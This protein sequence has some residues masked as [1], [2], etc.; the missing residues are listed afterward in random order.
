MKIY[1]IHYI[2]HNIIIRVKCPKW[3]NCINGMKWNENVFQPYTLLLMSLFNRFSSFISC[4]LL[5]HIHLIS[6]LLG[7]FHLCVLTFWSSIFFYSIFQFI[8]HTHTP[9]KLNDF[10]CEKH[11]VAIS[12]IFRMHWMWW[13]WLS[14]LQLFYKINKFRMRSHQ[15]LHPNTKCFVLAELLSFCFS[16][17]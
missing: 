6:L 5:R 1:L 14:Y 13:Y 17:N 2:V 12:R 7:S 9:L 3:T 16:L 11:H 4:F 10:L 15:K 8:H